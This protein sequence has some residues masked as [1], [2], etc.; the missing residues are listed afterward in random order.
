M[1]EGD[2]LKYLGYS[3]TM[4]L[5]DF[6]KSHDKDFGKIEVWRKDKDVI[7]SIA[8]KALGSA[9]TKIASLFKS[10]GF[11]I[12]KDIVE[13]K[14]VEEVT[15]VGLGLM[16]EGQKGAIADL[17]TQIGKDQGEAVTALNVKLETLMSE[18]SQIE[19]MLTAQKSE[20]ETFVKD[21]DKKLNGILSANVYKQ[22][23]AKF[24]F[25]PT[26]T[27]LEKR[28]F[29]TIFNERY[30]TSYDSETGTLIPTDLEGKKIPNPEKSSTF[31]GLGEVFNDLGDELG[32]KDN[33]EGSRTPPVKPTPPA[34]GIPANGV[35]IKG[36][37][38][39]ATAPDGVEVTGDGK[40]R[41]RRT[42]T[43]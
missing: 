15:K 18:K 1:S 43:V 12:E 29:E 20:H 26:A 35:P 33:N 14:T 13:S 4:S 10:N 23:F 9:T 7:A 24:T 31:K 36:A 32:V 42:E 19:T 37:P 22:E 28:G 25:K 38:A 5:E 8:G 41:I 21:Q 3:E 27:L 17:K 34:T 40:F 2:I 39:L 16:L 11:T 6:K 30:L